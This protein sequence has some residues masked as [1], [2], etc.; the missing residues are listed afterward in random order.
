MGFPVGHTPIR[1][2]TSVM[3][4]PKKS[5]HLLPVI[6]DKVLNC[7]NKRLNSNKALK[8][9]PTEDLLKFAQSIMPKDLSIRLT[10]DIRYISNTPRPQ[11]ID[12]TDGPKQVGYEN[13]TK[14]ITAKTVIEEGIGQ[15]DE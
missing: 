14:T 3:G 2:S 15:S 13:N 4:R 7:L 1:H 8:K 5:K 11:T 10:P 12:V 6:R 9:I